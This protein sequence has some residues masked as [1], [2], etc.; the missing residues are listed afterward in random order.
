MTTKTAKKTFKRK[1]AKKV[2][3][4]ELLN[5]EFIE[6]L[7]TGNCLPWT[8][9]WKGTGINA[10]TPTNGSTGKRYKGMNVIS[11]M[12]AQMQG[13]HKKSIWLTYKQAQ[14]L[15]GQV[16]KGAQGVHLTKYNIVEKTDKNSSGKEETKTIPF[17]NTF[18]VFN[19]DFIKDLP[20]EFYLDV[21]IPETEK[22]QAAKNFIEAL[23]VEVIH[24]GDMAAFYP[25]K[26]LI[27]M[28]N[29]G[30]F[31][32]EED[33]WTTLLHEVGH[34][35]GSKNRLARKKDD[36]AAEECVAELFAAMAGAMFGIS[37]DMR[38][39][40]YITH[41]LEKAK[42]GKSFLQTAIKEAE[43]ALTFAL[44][45]VEPEEK[46]QEEPKAA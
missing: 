13:E 37:G 8:K 3:A 28:P 34:W 29:K 27:T 1:P 9:N 6:S 35:T 7:E 38:H 5:N 39:E 2:D 20:E 31:K 23:G 25:S 14:S 22:Y 44:E 43:Q 26:D 30:D 15:G 36:Y 4:L 18:V 32:T 17:V 11:L 46:E 10:L 12:I 19:I 24:G 45:I 40:G 16:I 33:Y 41:W 21:A 42:Q